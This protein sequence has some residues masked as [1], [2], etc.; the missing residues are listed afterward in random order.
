MESDKTRFEVELEFVQ[1]LANPEYL[2][3]TYSAAVVCCW[4]LL[5][6]RSG[7][8]ILSAVLI[9]EYETASRCMFR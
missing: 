6:C 2:T 9:T 3:C 5:A 7:W 1:C 4:Q 8:N